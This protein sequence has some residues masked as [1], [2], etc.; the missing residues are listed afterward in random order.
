MFVW[1]GTDVHSVMF[2]VMYL[3]CYAT[4]TRVMGHMQGW[5][6]L[7]GT[8]WAQLHISWAYLMGIF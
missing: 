7:Q 1:A 6:I 3:R 2:K 8:G 4:M 5:A